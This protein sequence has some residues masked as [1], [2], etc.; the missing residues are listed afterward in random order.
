[1]NE[2][3]YPGAEPFDLWDVVPA[4]LQAV[5]PNVMWSRARLHRLELPVVELAVDELAWQ[6]DLPWWRAGQKHFALSPLD[7]WREPVAYASQWQR[8]L[9]ADLTYPI[10]VLERAPLVILD[11]VHRLLKAFGQARERINA[12]VVSH[13]LF[14]EVIIDRPNWPRVGH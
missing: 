11:G 5:V 2:P 8:T 1:M 7:V 14:V 13:R 9:A 3:E 6:L 10:H 12:C 4:R